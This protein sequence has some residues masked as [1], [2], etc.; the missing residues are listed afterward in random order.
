M[1]N[2][3]F[4]HFC[5][6]LQFCIKTELEKTVYVIFEQTEYLPLQSSR[7]SEALEVVVFPVS[8]GEQDCEPIVDL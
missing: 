2:I 1:T 3:I 4:R 6:W 5:A 7:E 8:H